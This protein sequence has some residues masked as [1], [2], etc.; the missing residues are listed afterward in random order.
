MHVGDRSADTIAA[1]GVLGEFT[2]VLVRDGY[3]GYEHLTAVHAWCGAHLLRDL[4]SVSDADPHGQLWALAMA[5]PARRQRCRAPSPR[6]WRRPPRQGHAQK[7][8]QPL[9]G[10]ARA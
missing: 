5:T 10:R 2:G 9:P 7:D 3:A 1:G 4:R 6:A 8:P